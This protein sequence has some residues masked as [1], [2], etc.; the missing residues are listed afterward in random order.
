MNAPSDEELIAIAHAGDPGGLGALIER[1]RAGMLAI[2][3]R[4]LGHR[5]EAEDVVQ[6]AIVVALA[7]VAELRNATAAGAWLRAIVRNNCLMALRRRRPAQTP[8]GLPATAPSAE[9]L[10]DGHLLQAW[11]FRGLDSLSEPLQLTLLLRYFSDVSSYEDISALSG[12]PIG[13]VRSR[14]AEGKRKLADAL[15]VA[16]SGGHDDV[17]E[18]TLRRAREAAHV[19]AEAQEGRFSRAALDIFDPRLNLIGPNREWGT[20]LPF[21]V[22]VLDQDRNDGVRHVLRNV[23]SGSRI[24]IWEMDLVS[25][26]S[27]PTH[28]PPSIAWAHFSSGDRTRR[29][30]LFHAPH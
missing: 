10:L 7:R 2:A 11:I 24:T 4:M 27:A 9:E 22:H 13:T 26:A 20:D 21:L 19:V 23:I 17:R 29:L 30:R 1:H 3:L 8:P 16:A 6:D 5:P 15:L 12:V 25:P 14:L 18:R 28:C